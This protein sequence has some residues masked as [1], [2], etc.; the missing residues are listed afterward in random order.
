MFVSVVENF[1][2]LMI[3]SLVAY[4]LQGL[5]PYEIVIWQSLWFSA[6]YISDDS[7]PEQFNLTPQNMCRISSWT[8]T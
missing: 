1:I 4:A 2:W 3:L 8:N 6:L 5:V 7:I